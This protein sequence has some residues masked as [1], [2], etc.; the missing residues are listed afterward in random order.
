MFHATYYS[1]VVNVIS[2]TVVGGSTIPT[3]VARALLS[4]A[5]P[6]GALEWKRT[7]FFET[8][9]VANL[10]G[11][12]SCRVAHQASLVARIFFKRT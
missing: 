3:L 10:H 7:S 1:R 12:S 6:V 9:P 2:V 5:A 8:R 11:H 4:C